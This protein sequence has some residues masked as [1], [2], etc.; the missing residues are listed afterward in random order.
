MDP[1]SHHQSNFLVFLLL[2]PLLP[3]PTYQIIHKNKNSEVSLI[4]APLDGE[5][6]AVSCPSQG[7]FPKLSHVIQ[8]VS[9]FSPLLAKSVSLR[10]Q[11]VLGLSKFPRIL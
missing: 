4:T 2:E 6:W 10:I 9:D 1:Q 5:F 11:S 3:T 8:L 7:P